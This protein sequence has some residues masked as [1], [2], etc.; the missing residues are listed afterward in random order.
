MPYQTL[1]LPPGV[2]SNGTVYQAKGRWFN[3]NLIRFY[4]GTIR[5]IGGWTKLYDNQETPVAVAFTETTH[6][7]PSTMLA[8]ARNDNG[9][10]QMAIGTNLQCYQYAQGVRVEITPAVFTT[11]SVDGAY[12]SGAYGTGAYGHGAYG[13]GDPTQSVLVPADT[14]SLDAWG[15]YLLGCFTADGPHV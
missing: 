8:W 3:A 10:A 2:A 6:G 5:P 1:K 13:V 7:K 9:A 11:G 15:D 4:E 12:A 14:W